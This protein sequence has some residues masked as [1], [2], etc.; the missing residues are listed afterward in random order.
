M[1]Q[2]LQ[3]KFSEHFSNS[4]VVYEQ[5]EV[6]MNQRIPQ[7]S[8]AVALI[9]IVLFFPFK[10]PA[11][12][13]ALRKQE[14]KPQYIY[15]STGAGPVLKGALLNFSANLIQSNYWGYSVK[16]NKS[17][18]KARKLP[19][20]YVSGL[21]IFGPCYPTDDLNTFSVKLMKEFPTTSKRVRFGV[22]AGPAFG[23]FREARFFRKPNSGWFGSNYDVRY[24]DSGVI[25]LEM[26]AKLALPVTPYIGL[27]T[28]LATCINSKLSYLGIEFLCTLG[29][30]RN[31]IHSKAKDAQI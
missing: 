27:E 21:C 15:I 29:K 30:V 17:G 8:G 16:Y 18:I 12:N 31:R 28:A 19:S 11:Q 26:R 24:T 13:A 20:D 7:I 25:G 23:T 6:E 10:N 2:I 9:L 22:E 3:K 4:H 14:V 1:Q 5:E